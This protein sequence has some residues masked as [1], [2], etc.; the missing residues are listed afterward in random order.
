MLLLM[1]RIYNEYK[2]VNFGMYFCYMLTT[3]TFTSK[4]NNLGF[5]NCKVFLQMISV[6]EKSLVV[7]MNIISL[8][9]M[10]T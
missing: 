2:Y 5:Y 1:N 8:L 7:R 3:L 6:T 10:T 9:P 4:H